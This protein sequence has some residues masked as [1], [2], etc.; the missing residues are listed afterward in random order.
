[1]SST[2]RKDMLTSTIQYQ[3]VH[4]P[5]RQ[6]FVFL[7]HNN[8]ICDKILQ[9]NWTVTRMILRWSESVSKCDY[10][11]MCIVQNLTTV[12]AKYTKMSITEFANNNNNSK[13][14]I[15]FCR[16]SPH[17]AIVLT[18][19]LALVHTYWPNKKGITA[20]MIHRCSLC[21]L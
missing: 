14:C 7:R 9:S 6:T 18:P 11:W 20:V 10:K 15:W 17:L 16:T 5:R 13:N 8:D 19:V 12:N 21:K 4:P 3:M 2:D 1:M